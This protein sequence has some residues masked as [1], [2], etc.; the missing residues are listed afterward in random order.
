MDI[1]KVN[2]MILPD[3]MENMNTAQLANHIVNEV[4]DEGLNETTL[5]KACL[6]KC[7]DYGFDDDK[8]DEIL[9]D[10][11]ENYLMVE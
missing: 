2:K 10:I 1:K 9:K 4:T 11:R 8:I 3:N 6:Q 5:Y 7:C